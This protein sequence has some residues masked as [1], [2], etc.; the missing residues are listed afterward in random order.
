MNLKSVLRRLG[1]LRFAR[2]IVYK[3]LIVATTLIRLGWLKYSSLPETHI[4]NMGNAALARGRH[5][6]AMEA[7]LAAL[8]KTPE[9][10]LLRLQ[11]GVTAFLA[12]HY[13]ECE[14]WFAALEE[15]K[16][17][18]LA[19]WGLKESGFRVLDRTWLLAI[20]HVA[21]IDTYIKAAHLGWFPKKT[22]LLAYNPLTPPSGWPMFRYFGEHVQIVASSSP[23]AAVDE[24]VHG[25]DYK[26]L[27]QSTRDYIRANLSQPFWFGPDE[28]GRTRWFAPF[29]A[30]VEAAWKAEG[31]PALHTPTAD[32]RRLFRRAMQ[33]VYGLPMDAWFV[34]LHVREPG[35]HASWHKHHPGTR[36]ADIGTYR[37]VIDFVLG[38]GGWVVRGGDPTM[39]KIP[40]QERVID[41]ATSVHRSPEMD[42]LLCAECQYF[43]GTNSGFSVVPPIFGKRCALTN[44]SPIGIPNWYLD[45]IY[46]PKLVRRRSDGRYLSFAEMFSGAAGW[47]Q[48]QSAYDKADLVIEDNE[49]DDLLA[50]VEELHGEVLGNAPAVTAEDA[51]R[52]RRFNE[53]A[54][55]NGGYVGSR[56]S[57]RF[58]A[59]YAHLLD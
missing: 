29:G 1:L 19:R 8:N 30:A 45:D 18:D 27:D 26:R 49:P 39:A 33:A 40:P 2:F 6:L 59:K 16:H 44:W 31:R 15:F 12:G 4:A 24:L 7:Y 14:K 23:D 20:G 54:V 21:F 22:A 50:T 37:K 11:I 25:E 42:I 3:Q 9:D 32:D 5:A 41:Y 57:Y 17:F 48:F 46:L 52:L 43:I 56:A 38:Q 53:I 34:V 47:S 10:V 51:A 55:A 28:T 13:H 35:Y 36:N 58:L